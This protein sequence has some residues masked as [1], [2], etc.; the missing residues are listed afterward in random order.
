MA[1]PRGFHLY[2]RKH[3]T[4]KLISMKEVVIVSAVRTP[5]GSF[6]GALSG[7]PA[8]QLGAIAIQGALAKIHLDPS[9][10]QEVFMGSVLQANLGQAPARQ[11]ALGAGFQRDARRVV[12]RPRRGRLGSR[13]DQGVW[14]LHAAGR[15]HQ[16]RELGR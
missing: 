14:R 8:T 9:T 15:G 4:L 6:Q 5:M 7:V 3:T 1:P 16:G 12:G 10:V 13:L 11:A 2:I